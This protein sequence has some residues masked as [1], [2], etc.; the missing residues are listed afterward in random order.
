MAITPAYL[1]FLYAVL[2]VALIS[3][4]TSTC[5][6]LRS[7]D[8]LL[9]TNS[10]VNRRSYTN[11]AKLMADPEYFNE[12]IPYYSAVPEIMSISQDQIIRGAEPVAVQK[13]NPALH[14][15]LDDDED[16]PQR[17]DAIYVTD[18]EFFN[19]S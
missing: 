10:N 14:G 5:R 12:E 17:R 19:E 8:R 9:Q 6:F 11:P 7:P 15:T 18:P 3:P 1:R 4:R 2:I 16:T 13:Y